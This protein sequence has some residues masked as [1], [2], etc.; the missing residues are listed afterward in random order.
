M[1]KN[2]SDRVLA[3]FAA[4][5][6][7][8]EQMSQ[9][10]KDVALGKE[11]FDDVT[12]RVISKAEANAKILDFSREVLG[13]TATS[14]KKEIR[15]AIEDN[16]KEWFRIVED[17]IDDS[18]T[19]GLG[20]SP[21]FKDLVE[22]KNLEYGDRQDFIAE[23]DSILAVA[24]M[25]ESHHD[26]ILQRLS[27]GQPISIPTYR[28]GVKVGADINKFIAGQIDWTKLVDT[29]TKAFIKKIQELVSAE[30][31]NVGSK[32][33]AVFKGTG[34]LTAGTKAEFDEVIS[35]VQGANDGVN[36]VIMGT[37][38]ALKKIT[39]IAD[40]DW[41]AK[42]QRDS[43]AQTGTIGIYEGTILMELPQRFED[44]TFTTKIMDDTK[45]YIM[46]VAEN[47]M[48]KFLDEGDTEIT[49]VDA[50]GEANGRTDDL[51][52]YE[53]QRRFGAGTVLGRMF[54]V[55]QLA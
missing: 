5:Q 28:Y 14:T 13:V 1:G 33:P 9:L 11:V 20:D 46:P 30:L 6:T 4:H 17:S 23:V 53:V 26:H 32:L 2:F 39:A 42:E 51:R 41:A 25:G 31:I 45:L 10:M 12:G 49:E 47:K 34:A 36:V 3:I 54:G 7:T 35:N 18:V 38:I 44:K 24:K 40:V 37:K 15:R 27:E 8:Y 43:V 52:S 16:G 19:V 21:W 29:I 50:K 48:I 55:W 22:N